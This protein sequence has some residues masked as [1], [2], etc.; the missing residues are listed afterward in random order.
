M[1]IAVAC[2]SLAA[3]TLV[4][5]RELTASVAFPALLT[6]DMLSGD[7]TSVPTL[8]NLAQR[9]WASIVRIDDYLDEE[10]VPRHVSAERA[11]LDFD[12]RL[13]C[14]KAAF[15]WNTTAIRKEKLLV[16][17]LKRKE[18]EWRKQRSWLQRLRVKSRREAAATPDSAS[19]TS[20]AV[21]EAQ[22]SQHQFQLTDISVLFPR[23][24]LSLISGPTGS[25][26][27]SRRSSPR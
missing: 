22:T 16:Q 12:E 27:S 4:A 10:E 3:F 18:G 24:K 9:G 13:G 21:N 19:A 14:E 20:T 26:K 8:I 11:P 1:P 23:G 2:I 6:F 7:L 15:M 5:R 25:G 17:E